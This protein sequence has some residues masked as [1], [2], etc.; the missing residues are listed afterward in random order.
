MTDLLTPSS[1]T[2]TTVNAGAEP[3]STTAGPSQV[4]TT[5]PEKPDEQ[6]FKEALAKAEQENAIAQGKVVCY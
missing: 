5:K 2:M 6:Q 4:P 3:P 1:V